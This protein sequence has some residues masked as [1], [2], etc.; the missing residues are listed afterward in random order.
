MAIKIKETFKLTT[1]KRI[2]GRLSGYF[3][4]FIANRNQ[5]G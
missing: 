3:N 2:G 4:T 5:N 1:M